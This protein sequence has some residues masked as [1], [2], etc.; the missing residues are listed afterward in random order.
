MTVVE[1]GCSGSLCMCFT[2]EIFWLSLHVSLDIVL[3]IIINYYCYYL[4]HTTSMNQN[5]I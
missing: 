5:C 2:N 1:S 3:F 4:F